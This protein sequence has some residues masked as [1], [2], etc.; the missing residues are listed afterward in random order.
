M[1]RFIAVFALSL[2]LVAVVGVGFVLTSRPPSSVPRVSPLDLDRLQVRL[3]QVENRLEMLAAASSRGAPPPKPALPAGHDSGIDD[4]TDSALQDSAGEDD[5]F[6]IAGTELLSR[7]E[8]METRLR[9]LEEDPVQRAYSFLASESAELRKRGVYGLKAVAKSDPAA[10]AAIRQM[11]GDPDAGVRAA[12]LDMLAGVGDR[13][14]IPFAVSLLDDADPWV[15]REAIES[16]ARLDAK[17]AAAPIAR[18]V[19][20]GNPKVRWQA[21]DAL[22]R[23]GN[24]DSAST[25]LAVAV[26]DEN[27]DIRNEAILSIGEIGA[28]EA[29]P[30]LR[31]YYRSV[32]AEG[33]RDAGDHRYRLAYAMKE[34]GEPDA[35][36]AELERLGQTVLSDENDRAR[37]GALKG[38]IWLGRDETVG[39]E[40]LRQ[41][42]EDPVEWIR[43]A[44]TEALEGK[45][46]D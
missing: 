10:R 22:G 6:G 9:G 40:I 33:A 15:R 14:A 24:K 46:R 19:G 41:A 39:Q 5:G 16:L 34:L 4:V 35:A 13:E 27:T 42:K 25:L 23:L 21:V 45:W 7:L 18:L 12:A 1:N 38:V 11:L 20:D 44:A 43:N 3:D 2:S 26:D 32:T 37:G 17:D 8:A 36:R 30:Q 28:T 29:L 31:E